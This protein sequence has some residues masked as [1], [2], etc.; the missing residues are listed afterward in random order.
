MIDFRRCNTWGIISYILSD[1]LTLLRLNLK[2]LKWEQLTCTHSWPLSYIAWILKQS[3]KR[4]ALGTNRNG[5]SVGKQHSF[6][7]NRRCFYLYILIQ[8]KVWLDLFTSWNVAY[9]TDARKPSKLHKGPWVSIDDYR[10]ITQKWIYIMFQ[11][12]QQDLYDANKNNN[13]RRSMVWYHLWLW[14]WDCIRWRTIACFGMASIKNRYWL[15][16]TRRGRMTRVSVN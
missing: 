11:I 2:Y 10:I 13:S 14:I 4:H 3:R 9:L 7:A 5:K 8:N 15:F 6:L 16:L 1:H 12:S